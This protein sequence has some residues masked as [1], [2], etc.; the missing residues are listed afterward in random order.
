[1]KRT[2]LR[3]IMKKHPVIELTIQQVQELE[4]RLE[5]NTRNQQMSL[6]DLLAQRQTRLS[7][8]HSMA[9]FDPAEHAGVALVV[10][11]HHIALANAT[12]GSARGM[13]QAVAEFKQHDRKQQRHLDFDRSGAEKRMKDLAVQI[14]EAA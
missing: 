14:A 2:H 1:L 6:D 13:K 5:T 4:F 11:T 8:R 12:Y 3:A 9:Q 7:L 10:N